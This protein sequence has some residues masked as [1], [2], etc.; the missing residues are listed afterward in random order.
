MAKLNLIYLLLLILIHPYIIGSDTNHYIL[1]DSGAP[2]TFVRHKSMLHNL[3]PSDTTTISISSCSNT[4]IPFK[5]EGDLILKTLN[6]KSV[7][8]HAYY[9]PSIDHT[10][11]STG[12]LRSH[13]LY[14]NERSNT[15]E[16]QD[17]SIAAHFTQNNG[18]S[19]L[20][21]RH[22]IF[23]KSTSL[24]T[25]HSLQTK[26]PL[27]LIHRLFG[28]VNVQS[29][30]DSIKNKTIQ[31]ISIDDID[32]RNLHKFQCVDCM[33]GKSR[34]RPHTVGSRLKYQTVYHPFQYIHSDLF[35]PV[36]LGSKPEWFIS[37]TDEASKFKWTYLLKNKEASTILHIL[38]SFI[39]TIERQFNSTILKFQFDRGTEYT[40]KDVR[41][42]L[43][44][45]GIQ[46]IYT[47]AGDSP[48]HGVAERLNLTLLNDCYI[49]MLSAKLLE[50]LWYYNV[51]LFHKY[52][53]LF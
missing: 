49:L 40:N 18:L 42:F 50:H 3:R 1:L 16:D 45:K 35:G 9:T 4:P 41:T 19:W 23:P 11:L 32:W 47:T 13:H 17:G 31:N 29:L 36:H 5:Q 51:H 6:H 34:K 27:E 46:I 53:N 44:E 24:K 21:N 20:S 10:I 12:D 48:A 37:F 43:Q 15:I 25:I 28:H 26:F 2:I 33:Q 39:A 14:M 52:S 30:H 8:I 38:K 22:V 7:K